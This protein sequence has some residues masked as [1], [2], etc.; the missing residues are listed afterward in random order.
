MPAIG[1][2]LGAARGA[3]ALLLSQ[4]L[5]IAED[6]A[7]G[8]VI[9]LLAVRRGGAGPWAFSLADDAGGRFALSGAF[10][11][12]AE[13]PLS[14]TAVPEHQIAITAYSSGRTLVTRARVEVRLSPNALLDEANAPLID[15]SDFTITGG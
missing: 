15:Q 9:G 6:A 10:L 12:K 11:V 7:A 3:A 13:A 8:T 5:L 4:P 2:H 1:P 14:V